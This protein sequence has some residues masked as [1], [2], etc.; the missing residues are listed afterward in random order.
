ML[1]A[2]ILNL[3]VAGTNDCRAAVIDDQLTS[4]AGCYAQS[5]SLAARY[6]ADRPNEEIKAI[7]CDRADRLW[8]HLDM[9][10]V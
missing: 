1:Y 5:Q 3:C 8:K 6:L 2:L 10:R 7:V 9:G 4:L